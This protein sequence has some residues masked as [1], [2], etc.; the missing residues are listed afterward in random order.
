[1]FDKDGGGTI[2]IKELASVM[3]TFGE[4]PKQAELKKMF[5]MVDAD[6][7]GEIDFNEFLQIM[8]VKIKGSGLEEKQLQGAFKVFYNHSSSPD[9]HLIMVTE[10]R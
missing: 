10:L 3:R 8:I 9:N 5:D 2:S 7:N 6:G 4:N 1:M